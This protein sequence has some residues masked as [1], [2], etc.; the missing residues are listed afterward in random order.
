MTGKRISLLLLTSVLLSSI[1]LGG[2][3]TPVG[4]QAYYTREPAE[5]VA[6]QDP[7]EDVADVSVFYEPLA[8][9][10]TWTELP[11]Y[12]QVWIP[13]GVPRRV[14]PLHARALGV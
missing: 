7:Q 4:G 6:Y 13:D 11:E 8:P 12:G 14:A 5:A 1:G 3:I 10:G 9:Y 2:C